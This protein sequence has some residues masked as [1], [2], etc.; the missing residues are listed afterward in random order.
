MSVLKKGGIE[1]RLKTK[2][3][4]EKGEQPSDIDAL[5]YQRVFSFGPTWKDVQVRAISSQ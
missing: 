2:V 5:S 4:M 3:K 1:F